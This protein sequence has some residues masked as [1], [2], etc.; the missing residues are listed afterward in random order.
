MSYYA[1]VQFN[2]KEDAEAFTLAQKETETQS[3]IKV[4]EQKVHDNQH[5][6]DDVN[7]VLDSYVGLT[8]EQ[9]EQLDI[10][11]IVQR[12]RDYDYSD[13]N[14]YIESLIDDQVIIDCV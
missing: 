8:K 10:D 14:N 11:R 13:Y 1:I 6:Y 7:T 12:L 3:Q 4:V 2:S 5:M 9:K